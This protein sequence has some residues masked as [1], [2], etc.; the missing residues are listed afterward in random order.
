[1]VVTASIALLSLRLANLVQLV[2]ACAANEVAT[3]RDELDD[4]A[5]FCVAKR[6]SDCLLVGIE[7]ILHSLKARIKMERQEETNLN[8]GI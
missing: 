3:I 8:R 4:V 7:R 6:T 2:V 5:E 1:M